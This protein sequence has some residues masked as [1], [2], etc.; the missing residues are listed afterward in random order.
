VPGTTASSR[1]FHIVLAQLSMGG[2]GQSD[3]GDCVAVRLEALHEQLQ[4]V[5]VRISGQQ[6]F[7]YELATQDTG[8][9]IPG[10]ADPSP[11]GA[12]DHTY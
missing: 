7:T 3:V 2:V 8:Q 6:T 12:G 1:L 5:L 4:H 10:Q 9:L 11:S